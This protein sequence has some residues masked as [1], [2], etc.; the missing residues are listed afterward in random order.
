MNKDKT[1]C[2]SCN[3]TNC[4]AYS[5][6]GS[7]VVAVPFTGADVSAD[8]VDAAAFA[9]SSLVWSGSVKCRSK[10]IAV[11]CL[12]KGF[13]VEGSVTNVCAHACHSDGDAAR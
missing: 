4:P 7:V 5:A 1:N 10:L 8:A 9:V 11:V 2:C 13:H 3:P 6:D 12:T